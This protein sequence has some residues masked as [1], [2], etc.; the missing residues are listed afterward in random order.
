MSS[1]VIVLASPSGG[2]GFQELVWRKIKIRKSLDEICHSMELEVPASER[3]KIRKHDKVEVRCYNRYISESEDN[4]KKR[5]VTTVMVDEITDVTDTNRKGLLVVGRSPAR[6]VIDSAWS[7]LVLH[8]QSL[9]RIANDIVSPFLD[10]AGIEKFKFEGRPHVTRMPTDGPET[11][12]VHSFSWDYES[13]WQKL[14]AEA[15]NQGYIFTSNEAGN[16]YLWKVAEE[17]RGEGF[18]L[19]EGSNIRDIQATENGAEQF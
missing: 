19:S 14:A 18:F 11:D 12:P 2:G 16:L 9:E 15:D 3:N 10:A 13:P 8:Q 5:R 1:K 7:D 17:L 4:D 6:D